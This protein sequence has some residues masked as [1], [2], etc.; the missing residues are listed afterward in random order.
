M[1]K[2]R[3]PIECVAP[4]LGCGMDEKSAMAWIL[5]LPSLKGRND[6]LM[7]VL[8]HHSHQDLPIRDKTLDVGLIFGTL[9]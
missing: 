6:E 5:D 9:K 7:V 2:P 3:I 8:R 4:Q 1:Q